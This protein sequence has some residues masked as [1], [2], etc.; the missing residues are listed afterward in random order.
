MFKL[1]EKSE[2]DRRI[3]KNDYIR[4]SPS[5]VSTMNAPNRQKYIDK[6]CEDSVIYLL[7][8]SLDSKFEAVKKADDSRYADGN[9]IRLVNLGRIELFSAY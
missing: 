5:E 2:N 8:I 9:D 7:Y 3:Q 4:S 1:S 6:P